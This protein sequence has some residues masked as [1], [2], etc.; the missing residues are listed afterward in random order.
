M[1][2]I[3]DLKIGKFDVLIGINL[4]REGL[5]VPEVSLVMILDADREGFLRSETSLIQTCGRASR[6]IHGRV[7]LYG[8]TMTNSM[9]RCIEA[10]E[11]RRKEQELYNQQHNIT[12]MPILSNK[13][14]FLFEQ[15]KKSFKYR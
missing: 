2:I 4:L 13:S 3:N 12:P 9:Q 15:K 6:N 8:D 10:T 1:R 14:K 5:D 7:I 11:I